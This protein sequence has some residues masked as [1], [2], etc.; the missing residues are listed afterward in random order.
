MPKKKIFNI[1]KYN[2]QIKKS[3][4]IRGSSFS[5]NNI[6][7]AFDPIFDQLS[8]NLSSNLRSK[9]SHFLR[10]TASNIDHILTSPN[11]FSLHSKLNW[12]T[13]NNSSIELGKCFEKSAS[14]YL[15][16]KFANYFHYTKLN[17]HSEYKWLGASTDGMLKLIFCKEC[18]SILKTLYPILRHFRMLTPLQKLNDPNFKIL[19]NILSNLCYNEKILVEFKSIGQYCLSKNFDS[20]GNLK[21]GSEIYTQVQFQLFICNSQSCILIVKN[22]ELKKVETH[23]VLFDSEFIQNTFDKIRDFYLAKRL[24]YLIHRYLQ[25]EKKSINFP[26][27]N[28]SRKQKI[29]KQ[30]PK[31]KRRIL[32]MSKNDEEI[33]KNLVIKKYPDLF[34][35]NSNIAMNKESFSKYK[36]SSHDNLWLEAANLRSECFEFEKDFIHTF[37]LATAQTIKE[38]LFDRSLVQLSIPLF[39]HKKQIPDST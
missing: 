39:F 32:I 10:I 23:T 27:T 25:N 24:P 5:L 15:E 13:L 22:K 34:D 11:S 17:V 19:I 2:L 16:L 6:N 4:K 18:K 31:K 30:I 37:D 28:G 33:F 29:K 7:E 21:A 12:L 9:F 3:I 1:S 8:N 20:N 35:S 14:N 38:I 36:N 26:N